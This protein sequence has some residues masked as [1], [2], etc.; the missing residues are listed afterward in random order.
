M[1]RIFIVSSSFYPVISPRSFRA[2]ELAKELARQGHQVTVFTEFRNADYDKIGR[3]F[4]LSLVD[5]GKRS[6]KEIKIEGPNLVSLFKRM[7]RRILLQCLEYPDIEL[8]YLV[9]RSLQKSKGCDLLITI[10]VPYPIHW[11]A[12]WAMS[13]QR[14]KIGTWVA[15][16]GDPYV[17]CA[18]D[19]FKKLFYFAY[20]EKWFCRKADY[21]SIPI[22]S[23][24]DGYFKE[25]HSKIRVVPQGFDFKSKP[26]VEKAPAECGKGT[27]RFA[28][29]GS[30]MPGVRDPRPFLNHLTTLKTLNFQFTVFTRDTNLLKGFDDKLGSS[31]ILHDYI[32]R[33][34]LLSA[35]KTQDFLV[36]FDNNTNTQSPSKLIDYKLVGRPVLNISR[37]LNLDTIDEFLNGN[38]SNQLHLPDLQQ[39][40]IDNVAKQ[41]LCLIPDYGT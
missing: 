27:V 8:M 7:W 30:F 12:A 5:L 31:L 14:T 33:E 19:S 13:T 22:E 40:S 28:Y 3:D 21:L 41:F 25:F 26:T 35:L 17:G 16:C 9:K 6:F 37:N 10:A 11:G 39:H 23:A 4:N 15:D 20:V 38:Y 1:K 34:E 32:P 36:N 18:T 2:T 24:T 29:A